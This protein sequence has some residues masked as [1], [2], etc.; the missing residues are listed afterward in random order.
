MTVSTHAPGRGC[1]MIDATG[2]GPSETTSMGGGDGSLPA[3]RIVGYPRPAMPIAELTFGS[4]EGSLSVRSFRIS[5]AISQGFEV[6]VTARSPAQVDLD[7]LVGQA[8][9]LRIESGLAFAHAGARTWTGVC[10]RAEQLRAE[11]S[12]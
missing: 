1:Q 11:P 7:T 10:Q 6:T 8:A 9:A 4:H 12:G 2:S 3:A 5:E